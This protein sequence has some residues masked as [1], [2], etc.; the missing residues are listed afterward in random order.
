[1]LK[2]IQTNLERKWSS[3]KFYQPDFKFLFVLNSEIKFNQKYI[4][5]SKKEQI[6]KNY[7]KGT[8]F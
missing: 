2:I 1:M 3:Y 4:L 6:V 5:S 7:L 8:K